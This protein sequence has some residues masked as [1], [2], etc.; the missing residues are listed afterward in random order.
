LQGI[1]SLPLGFLLETLGPEGQAAG[2]TA[3]EDWSDAILPNAQQS[4]KL[5]TPIEF[6][7]LR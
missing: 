7:W 6:A 3:A 4:L 1:I 5:M 2:R